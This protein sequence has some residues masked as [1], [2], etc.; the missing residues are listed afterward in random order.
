[1]QGNRAILDGRNQADLLLFS[2][3]RRL[4]DKSLL[5]IDDLMS[6]Y[7]SCI[8]FALVIQLSEMDASKVFSEG[9][10][11]AQDMEESVN[12]GA[13]LGEVDGDSESKRQGPSAELESALKEADVVILLFDST[14][15][16]SWNFV[17][18]A[19]VES[20]SFI[21][22]FLYV[23]LQAIFHSNNSLRRFCR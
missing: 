22:A 3:P 23:L 7:D 15:V 9:T 14:S 4:F 6:A 13:F 16:E 10:T 19:Q 11:P 21:R 5:L 8:A 1:V 18:A 2:F 17:A 20:L 12:D